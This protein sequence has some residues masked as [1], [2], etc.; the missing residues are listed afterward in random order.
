[1]NFRLTKE[2]EAF[3][4][5]VQAFLAEAWPE[6]KRSFFPDNRPEAYQEEVRFRRKMGERGYLSLAWPKKY[7]GQERTPMEQFLFHW[8]IAYAGA[9][10]PSTA[11]GIV[12]PTLMR[13]GSEEQKRTYLPKI[14]SG[15]IDFCLGYT[16]PEAGSD[17]AALQT[18]SVREGDHY[19]VS[20]QKIFTS[21]AHE[22]EY[23]WL[24][25]RTDPD[26]PKHQ[27]ISLL[28]ADMSAPGIEVRPLWTMGNLRTNIVYWDEVRIPVSQR[29]GEENKGW[30]YLA[31]AL[32]YE[33]IN[34]FPGPVSSVVRQFER[35]VQ[36]CTQM[37][38]GQQLL[39]QDPEVRRKLARL[40]AELQA[41]ILLNFKN[42]WIVDTGKVPNVEASVL[43]VYNAEFRQKLADAAME[44]L[45]PYAQLEASSPYALSEGL[46]EWLPRFNVFMSIGGG[47]DEI[48]R[49]I[50]AQRGLGL[51]RR[52]G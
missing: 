25:V 47:A 51:P 33:R 18:R 24:A 8:E 49:N 7:G 4:E 50:I 30:Y 21:G 14:S 27:G 35:F 29:V 38:R 1:M 40:S 17:L 43:K 41:L 22:T 19:V 5:E 15:E 48:Q 12:A 52:E 9:P 23:C 6:E 32:D 39:S 46:W 16:E 2:Q 45:G 10:F 42:A 34:L 20:G 37:R 36:V 13:Y 3:R 31:T 11:V 44:V 26:A 28:I